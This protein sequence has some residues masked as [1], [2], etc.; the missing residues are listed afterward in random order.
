MLRKSKL[1][2]EKMASPLELKPKKEPI[3][4]EKPLNDDQPAICEVPT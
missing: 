3:Q 1:L 4:M 2:V